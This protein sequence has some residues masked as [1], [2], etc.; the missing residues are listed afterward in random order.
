MI[1]QNHIW[2]RQHLRLFSIMRG[3]GRLGRF[4]RLVIFRP[5]L[6]KFRGGANKKQP[7]IWIH[8]LRHT[9]IIKALTA[10]LEL[11]GSHL[12]G[13]QFKEEERMCGVDV[14][15]SHFTYYIGEAL[16]GSKT[17]HAALTLTLSTAALQLQEL[18]GT[19]YPLSPPSTH[20]IQHQ[21]QRST[22]SSQHSLNLISLAVI[23]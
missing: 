15:G 22:L 7:C 6:G 18:S 9:V 19:I 5:T 8:L 17:V 12:V 16:Q 1:L 3:G 4:F 13:R 23:S 10:K 2:V 21:H 14:L 11:E 20:C